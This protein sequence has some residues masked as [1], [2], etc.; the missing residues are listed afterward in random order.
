MTIKILNVDG[1]EII[2]EDL[3]GN[4]GEF[5][6][7]IDINNAKPGVYIIRI[8]QDGKMTTEKIILNK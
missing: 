8:E 2:R 4:Q 6:K 1:K 5:E 7:T 3:K